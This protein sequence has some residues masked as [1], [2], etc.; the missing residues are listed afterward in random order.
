MRRGAGSIEITVKKKKSKVDLQHYTTDWQDSHKVGITPCPP[1]RSEAF[2]LI[3][4]L[5]IN[6]QTLYYVS[7][8]GKPASNWAE[9]PLVSLQL[10]LLIQLL[11]FTTLDTQVCFSVAWIRDIQGQIN[12]CN[13]ENRAITTLPRVAHHVFGVLSQNWKLTLSPDFWVKYE[14]LTAQ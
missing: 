7:P 2:A 6:S 9:S 4:W 14:P 12:A 10:R 5:T 1:F 8:T 13:M 3:L 11:G